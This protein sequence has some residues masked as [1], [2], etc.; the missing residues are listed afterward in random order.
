MIT[1]RHNI[2]CMII[3][4]AMSKGSLSGCLVHLD[5]GS[6][7]CLKRSKLAQQEIPERSTSNTD[8]ERTVIGH[9]LAGLLM[10]VCLSE[11]G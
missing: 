3:I 6:T 4:I 7:D 10:P 8:S 11:T 1:E 9:Y 5:A 2:A